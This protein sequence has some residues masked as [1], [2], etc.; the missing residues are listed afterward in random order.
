MTFFGY[1]TLC[2]PRRISIRCDVEQ[3]AHRDAGA[4]AIGVVDEQADGGLEIRNVGQVAH[5]AYAQRRHERV[6]VG[7]HLERGHQ[8]LQFPEFVDAGVDQASV[9]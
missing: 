5:A 3:V 9:K 6:R 7:L 8:G 1:S 4:R 2:G